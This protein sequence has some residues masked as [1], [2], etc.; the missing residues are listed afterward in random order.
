AGIRQF[1]DIGT[2]L[3]AAGSAHEIAQAVVPECR[4]VYVDNDPMVLAHARALLTGIEPGT[5]AYL[6]ADLRDTSALLEQ[7][8]AELDFS[9]P[10]GILL[11]SV[12]HMIEDRE[13]PQAIVGTL[14]DA[15]APGSFLVLT[16]V[17]SDLEPE[18]MAEMARRVNQH[19]AKPTTPRD[20]AT[21]S[22]FFGTLELVPP[23]LVRVPEWRPESAGASATASTQWGGAGRKR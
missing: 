18:A 22:R 10:V 20:Y 8:A 6:D 11:I 13:D 4:V 7:A 3:P 16:H 17:A 1:L 14:L 2:G 15:V 5:T 23:G 19:V 9:R 12:L 21:V